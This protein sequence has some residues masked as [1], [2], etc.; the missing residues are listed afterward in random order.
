MDWF[1]P[2]RTPPV[3]TVLNMGVVGRVESLWRY[4]VKSMRGE[5]LREAYLT[6]KGVYGDR[7]YAFL[8]TGARKDFPYFT[9]REQPELLQHR[10]RYLHPEKMIRPKGE[11][12]LAD[13]AIEVETPLGERLAVDDPRLIQLLRSGL[14]EW[15][16]KRH[17]VM[18]VQSDSPVVDT[19]PLSLFCLQTVGRLSEE[20]GEELDKRRFR[21]NVYV[22]L[23]SGK[24]FDEDEWVGRRLRIGADAVVEILKRT[25]RCKLITLDPDT[26][27]RNIEL[28]RK[29]ALEHE[30]RAGISAGVV[31]E[32]MIAVGD[33]MRMVG[34]GNKR[35]SMSLDPGKSRR[36]APGTGIAEA[37][38]PSTRAFPLP[39]AKKGHG[40]PR[41]SQLA[42]DDTS[43]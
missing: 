21:A 5:E 22:D 13:G 15:Q 26:S 10:A 25:K 32:G 33:E 17:Q 35:T 12:S 2:A 20:L 8:S 34:R 6:A 30:L 7:R 28:M 18:V 43:V 38:V 39:R 9:A 14:H 40:G 29:I 16:Q 3:D 27:E 41:V 19:R 24:G 42:Q 36:G 11:L 4:P 37:A 31:V 1:N 23:A